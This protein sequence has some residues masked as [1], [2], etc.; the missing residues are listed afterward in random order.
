M[1][2]VVIAKPLKRPLSSMSPSII[3]DKN[4]RVSLIGGASGGPRI[5]TATAQVGEQ[6][7]NATEGGGGGGDYAHFMIICIPLI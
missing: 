5:I 4:K 3:L 2:F 6:R 1:S 7:D